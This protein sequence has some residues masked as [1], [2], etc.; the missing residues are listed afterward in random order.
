MTDDNDKVEILCIIPARGGSKRFPGKNLYPLLDQPLLSYP[1]K[2]AKQIKLI[3]RII[4][5]TDEKEI[6]RSARSYGAEVPFLRP[7]KFSMDDSP[8][9]EAVIFTLKELKKEKYKPDYI[10]L[11]QTVNPLLNK[12]QVEE[13]INLAIKSGAD[14]VVTVAPVDT[15]SHPYN[16]RIINEDGFASFWLK[17]KHY[18]YLGKKKPEYFKIANVLVSSYET[19]IESKKFEGEKNIPLIVDSVSSLDIDY[20]SDLELIEAFMKYVK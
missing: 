7:E 8:V 13:A 16:L 11:L 17:D 20:K 6:A 10:I 3:N 15:S 5:S 9:I 12:N 19:I 18:S 1:I 4:V 2:V 14:S